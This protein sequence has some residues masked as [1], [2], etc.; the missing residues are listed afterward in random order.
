RQLR[1]W[2][3][4]V[5]PARLKGVHRRRC[6]DL[7]CCTPSPLD[8]RSPPMLPAP[9]LAQILSNLSALELQP[10]T[11]AQILAAILAPLM[12]SDA[13]ASPDTEPRMR[14]RSR[15]RGSWRR[16]RKYTR[17]MPGARARALELL[18]AN[19]ERTNVKIARSL[20]STPSP[21][22]HAPRALAKEERKAK[23]EP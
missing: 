16:K 10:D 11:A 6:A 12:R 4:A 2:E 20:K 13:S 5:V 7:S 1:N 22:H 14:P 3:A 8:C 23:R 18:R 15:P 9:E 21:V 19:S 17:G